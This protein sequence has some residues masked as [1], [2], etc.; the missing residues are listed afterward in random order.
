MFKSAIYGVNNTK[1]YKNMIKLYYKTMSQNMVNKKMA[2]IWV[3]ESQLLT[4]AKAFT[5]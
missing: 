4:L 2:P 1:Q 3:H 5:I